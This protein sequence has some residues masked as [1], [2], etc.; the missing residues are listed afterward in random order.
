MKDN[1]H[2]TG[3][4]FSLT[5]TSTQHFRNISRL[6][7]IPDSSLTLLPYFFEGFSDNWSAC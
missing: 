7:V 2:N 1:V 6:S 5:S 4:L 3:T